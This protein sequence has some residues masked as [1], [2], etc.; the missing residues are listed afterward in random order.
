MNSRDDF[1]SKSRSVGLIMITA[2]SVV[3]VLNMFFGDERPR[4]GLT[5]TDLAVTVATLIAFACFGFGTYLAPSRRQVAVALY[6]LAVAATLWLTVL[7]PD[8]PGE[9]MLFVIAGAAAA[10]LPLRHSAVVMTALVLGF[11]ATV[12]SRTDDLGQL[13]SL[14]GVL[15]MYAGITAARNR[16]RTQHIEQQNLVLAER[17]RIAREI[18][19]ILAHSL[20]AQLVHLEGAR[21]LANA[22]RTDEA[23]DR[24]ERARELARGGLTETRRALDTLR[25]ETLKVDEALRELADEHREAT[26]GTCTVTVTGEPRDLAAEAGLALVR[27]AQEALTNVRKHAN[28]AD[29]TIELRYRDDDCELEVVDTGGRG[30]ALAETGSGYGLVGMRERAELIGGT[31]RAGP[32]DGGF[33]V[34]LRVPSSGKEVGAR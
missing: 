21:L 17:A 24:I 26:S 15:G 5:G 1:A 18:H 9:L 23:V 19:D 34:E 3:F 16:R 12:L 14:V 31:L 7:A 30:V 32:R 2:L 20:S 29:V 13:W 27:T 28:G 33:A 4:L 11:A 10:R 8:R 6:L 25:G 22:G